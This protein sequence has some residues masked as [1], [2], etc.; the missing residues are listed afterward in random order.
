MNGFTAGGLV[1]RDVKILSPYAFLGM[2]VVNIEVDAH[3]ASESEDE[4]DLAFAVGT[5]LKLTDAFSLYGEYA[6][7]DESFLNAGA[8]WTF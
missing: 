1:S 6:H 5:L 8:R 3:G 4:T 7:V 2:S